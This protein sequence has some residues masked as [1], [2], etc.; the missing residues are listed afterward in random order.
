MRNVLSPRR[1]GIPSCQGRRRLPRVAGLLVLLAAILAAV[2]GPPT[3]EEVEC[4]HLLNR[5][6]AD[7]AGEGRRL[8][9]GGSLG[10]PGSPAGIDLKLC[11]AELAALRPVPPLVMDLRLLDAARRHA[12]WLI[13]NHATGHNQT[14]GTPAFSGSDPVARM[15]ASGFA[16]TPSGENCFA[17]SASPWN[18]IC[19]YVIDWG[20]GE[21]SLLPGRP[22][23]RNLLAGQVD[24]I[25]SA[26]VPW[27]GGQ[28]L[29][30]VQNFGRS[31]VRLAGGVAYAD[32][33]RNGRFDAGEGIGGVAVRAGT[34][35]TTTWPS[36]GWALGLDGTEA[37]TITFAIADAG[38]PV[39]FA[40]GSEAVVIDC[41]VP[42][43]GDAATLDRLAASAKLAGEAGRPGRRNAAIALDRIFAPRQRVQ[44]LAALCA[45]ERSDLLADQ[46]RVREAVWWEDRAAAQ[47][48]VAQAAV[49]WRGSDAAAWFSGADEF[50]TTYATCIAFMEQV[51]QGKAVPA[52]LLPRLRRELVQLG[53]RQ[54]FAE[55]RDACQRTDLLF[56]SFEPRRP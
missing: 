49:R 1:A 8:A 38:E 35:A 55:W 30:S 54:V 41:L 2:D 47:A 22:H 28:H 15:V 56:D 21:G 36:G 31:R 42:L 51:L 19:G 53:Q 16:G 43:P 13:A 23:R 7:P 37:G 33:N 26:L 32:R 5:F 45:A 20:A 27:D 48:A 6:R 25:G 34:A 17:G 39:A 50:A 18:A 3:A 24:A 9:W 46:D 10:Y 4:L 29:A 44:A 40:A 14:P 11:R 52:T 12:D